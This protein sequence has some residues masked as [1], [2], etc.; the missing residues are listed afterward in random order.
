M[1]LPFG[2]MAWLW[3]FLWK[4]R[5]QSMNSKIRLILVLVVMTLSSALYATSWVKVANDPE[6]GWKMLVD[7]EE[8][9]IHGVVWTFTP[10]GD[11][12]TY[13]L[14]SQPDEFIKKMMDRDGVLLQ[15]MGVNVIRCF[16]TIPPEWITYLYQHYGI[17]TVVN[18]LFGRYGI[19]VN[20][21]YGKTDYSDMNTRKV[22][23]EQLEAKANL[24]KDVPGVL[25][26]LLGNENNYG[27]E[28]ES[29]AIEDL[30]V[31]Q[32]Q[33]AKAGYLYSLFE[34]G[35]QLIKDID[36]TKP[37][38]IVNGDL[39][40]LNIIGALC[41]SL[42]IL[43]VNTYRG[44]E[45]FD[46]FY[47]SVQDTVNVPIIYTELGADA[48]NSVTWQEDQYNQA[49]IIKNQ[50]K[51]IYLQSYNKGKYQNCLG[52]FVFEWV[53]E[54]W[55]H[56]MT[57]NLD[58]HDK[59]GTWTNGGYK[60]DA[61][62]GVKNMNEEWFGLLAQSQVKTEGIN[63]RIP[64]I[65]Y[66][67]LRDLW[68]LD[69]LKSTAEE[70]EA[71]FDNVD[72]MNY[73]SQ[74]ES[75]SLTNQYKEDPI[76]SIS[77][78]ATV[79]S[80]GYL[81][82]TDWEESN[83][84]SVESSYG[85]WATLGIDVAPME[86]LAAG[87]TFRIQGDVPETY[88]ESEEY[89]KYD[90]DTVEVYDGYF[91]YESENFELDGYYHNG[92]SDWVGE[93]DFFNLL[94]ESYDFYWMDVD[95]SKAPI[96]LE[97]TGKNR[98]EGL[99]VYGGPEI[100]W[101]ADPQIMAKYYSQGDI[102]SW[103]GIWDEVLDA[104]DSEVAD[105]S[106][107]RRVSLQG[108]LDF[109]PWITI[110][111]GV[112]HSGSAKIGETYDFVDSDGNV[113]EDEEIDLL[114]TLAGKIEVSSEAFLYTTLFARY[115]YNGLVAE[116]NGT[117]SRNGTQITDNGTGNRSEVEVGSR[118]SYGEW[119]LM[120]KFLYRTPLCY[121]DEDNIKESLYDAFAVYDNREAIEME[122]LVSWDPTGSTYFFEWDNDEREDAFAAAY[123]SFLY[124][125]YEGPTDSVSYVSSS[126]DTYSF[127][128][129]LDAVYGLWSLESR[130]VLNPTRTL[131][132]VATG[133]TGYGQST[134][135]DD[136]IVHYYCADVAARHGNWMLELSGDIDYWGGED[137][138]QEWNVTYPLQWTCELA[139]GFEEPSF[140]TKENRVGLKW[141]G[142]TYDEY[143]DD[144]TYDWQCELT[145]Y[146]SVNF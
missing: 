92:H 50:W 111:V 118:F 26:Y 79:L 105:G 38:G 98:L 48:F 57:T 103:S 8:I 110:D 131:K 44:D 78:S 130:V 80:K 140:L 61:A 109:A 86:N 56:G 104:E 68:K 25:F 21:R 99:K 146:V 108:T 40:Y 106:Y 12:Y 52:G 66:Y 1:I 6:E 14:W 32:Q 27:L 28:W 9:S 83:K 3:N 20:G 51:E 141:K 34:E 100:Y 137:W 18:D 29:D 4:E 23:L 116:S 36:P 16:S 67:M 19:S 134:G 95:D 85:E 145:T 10:I 53:D 136:R 46:M 81:N 117:T 39:Q 114:D 89:T 122:W 143:S 59:E 132:V 142:R 55:K 88:F 87:L 63:N 35:I 97:F 41:P 24:Y 15:D 31:G 94:S 124:S 64:R 43:G 126:G 119:A 33:E 37:V 129:G 101:G 30:P 144:D 76:V 62:S 112:L 93:G 120:P 65:A 49:L 42:D 84:E 22:I 17:Y 107:E 13:S 90:A 128:D 11:N 7:G 72:P 115:N 58:V 2:E 127:G 82:D 54:W 69:Q 91:N 102:L 121:V 139:Y 113:T 5:R 47:E 73:Y 60:F 74:S 123:L 70:V 125:F 75:D 45:S 135:G 138:Y 133:E 77:G 96:G 71:H